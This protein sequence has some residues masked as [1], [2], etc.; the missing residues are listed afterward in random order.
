MNKI[1][2]ANEY[3]GQIKELTE[4]DVMQNSRKRNIVEHRSLLVYLLRSVEKWKYLEITEYFKKNKK[5][6]DHTTAL[7]AYNSF[8]FYCKYNKS[9]EILFYKLLDKNPKQKHDIINELIKDFSYQQL[10]EIISKIELKESINNIED[11]STDKQNKRKSI[12][13]TDN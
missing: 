1:D 12:E 3:V 4:I 10:C 5:P 2:K 6:Y 7:Y 11:E 8:K 13:S 9:L